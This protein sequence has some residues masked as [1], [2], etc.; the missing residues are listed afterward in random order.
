MARPYKKRGVTPK[1]TMFKF[2]IVSDWTPTKIYELDDYGKSIN[3]HAEKLLPGESFGI[4]CLE[5]QR[6][7]KW[8]ISPTMAS[9]L[10][11]ILHKGLSV[12]IY[13]TLS[14]HVE[15]N[16]DNIPTHI[17]IRRRVEG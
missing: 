10:R 13:Q 9:S 7:Y 3:A 17:R 2:E 1:E 8:N 6:R 12:K 5:L 16:A 4:P 11:S 14:V 15:K